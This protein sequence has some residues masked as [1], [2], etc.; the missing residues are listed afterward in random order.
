M[1]PREHPLAS[2]RPAFNAV[3]VEAES[4][5][6]VDVLRPGAGGARPPARVLGDVVTAARNRVTGP[7]RPGESAYC[8]PADPAGRRGR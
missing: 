2:V 6:Q 1:I 4:A 8:Q 5:G 7:G 3:F